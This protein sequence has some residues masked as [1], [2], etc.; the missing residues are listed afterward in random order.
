MKKLKTIFMGTPDICLPTLGELNKNSSIELVEVVSMPDRPAGRGQNLK[1][2]DVIEYCK[3]HNINF[4]Q[5][6][7]IN[8]ENEKID[9]WKKQKIDLIIVF[10]FAQFL[11]QKILTLPLSGCFNIHTSLLPKYRGAAPIQHAL[12]NGE[13]KTGVSIQKM[14]KK[15]D[16]GDIAHSEEVEISSEETGVT[17]YEKLKNLSVVA[18]NKFITKLVNNELNYS[19]QEESLVTFAPTLKKEAGFLDFKNMSTRKVINLVRALEPWPGTYCFLN[20]KRLRVLK[21]ESFDMNLPAG[22]VDSSHNA[23]VVGCTDGA[24]RLKQVQLEGKKLV[25]D[26]ELLKGI[27]TEIK[28]NS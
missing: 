14:I 16:A 18:L 26:N 13:T 21:V 11:G 6:A 9:V 3:S 4:F 23:L 1:S 15:M 10:A 2:P 28:I 5:T 8:L 20:T 25:N 7:N 19:S 27:K 12:I 22:K 17:L 24:L